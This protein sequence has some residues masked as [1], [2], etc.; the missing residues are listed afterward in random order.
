MANNSESDHNAMLYAVGVILLAIF[1]AWYF[2][3]DYVNF[4]I[5]GL[6]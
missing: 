6:K 5:L 4:G 3:R 1:L 2:S